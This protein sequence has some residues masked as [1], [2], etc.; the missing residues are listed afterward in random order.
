MLSGN[1]KTKDRSVSLQTVNLKIS[2]LFDK[3][4]TLLRSALLLISSAERV[5]HFMSVLR[6]EL[7]NVLH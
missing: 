1:L 4:L 6:L 2:L 3:P 5:T 7:L